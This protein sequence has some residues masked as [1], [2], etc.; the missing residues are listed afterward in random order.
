[1]Y[2]GGGSDSDDAVDGSDASDGAFSGRAEAPRDR[3]LRPV[4]A[5]EDERRSRRDSL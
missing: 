5:D 2:L 4:V 1:M 3:E